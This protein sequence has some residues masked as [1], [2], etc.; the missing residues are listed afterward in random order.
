REDDAY[1]SGDQE[2]ADPTT[3]TFNNGNAILVLLRYLIGD[4]SPTGDLVWGGGAAATDFDM[5]TFVAMANVCDETLDGKPRYRLGGMHVLDG[6]LEGLVSRWEQ[7]TGGKLSKAGGVYRV[8]IPHDDLTP[9]TTLT[10]DDVLASGAITHT[11]ASDISKLY[12]TA[13][14]RYISAAEGYS[15]FP[16]AEVSE[17]DQV[18]EDNN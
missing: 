7:E 8:W 13:R 10:E 6:S 2:F 12:N 18:T 5:D 4:Y 16:Y 11:A 14:G 17:S 3:W 1:G 15:G 9:L